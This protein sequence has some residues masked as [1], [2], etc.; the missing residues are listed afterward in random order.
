MNVQSAGIHQ[1]FHGIAQHFA[2]SVV[3]IAFQLHDLVFFPGPFC[4]INKNGPEDIG[5]FLVVPFS[6]AQAC[7]QNGK[8][9]RQFMGGGQ[10]RR[11][12]SAGGGHVFPFGVHDFQGHVI[13]GDNVQ[14]SRHRHRKYAVL[15]ADSASAFRKFRYNHVF[16]MEA[17]KAY[18]RRNDIHNGVDGSHFMEMDFLYGKV[19]SFRFRLCHNAE[20]LLC[21]S[22]GR[23]GHVRAIND[24]FHIFQMTVLV[25]MV[26]FSMV[27][28]VMVFMAVAVVLFLFV[29]MAIFMAVA[30]M[31]FLLMMVTFFLMMVMVFFMNL[32]PCFRQGAIEIGHVVV[33]V[34]MVFV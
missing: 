24:R 17:V 23:F 15:A 16:D 18:G 13:G 21:Q 28:M 1:F 2:G 19:V 5:P 25:M 9:G 11:N 33:M 34:F 8:G 29:M 7:F 3:D 12:G 14:R 4:F 32:F 20:N 31:F 22:P 26:P 27:M 6:C 10:G 30:V